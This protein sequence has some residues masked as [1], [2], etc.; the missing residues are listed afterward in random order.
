[1][2]VTAGTC[3]VDA[4]SAV[5]NCV[6]GTLAPGQSRTVVFQALVPGVTAPGTSL[7]NTATLTSP[8]VDTV[9]ANRVA[10]AT[11]TVVTSADLTITKTPVSAPAVAGSSQTYL[12]AVHNTGPSVSRGV[13]VTDAL[14]AGLTF[15]SAQTSVGTCTQS[16]GTV[17]CALGDL[18]AGAAPTIQITAKLD[19]GLGGTTLTNTATIASAP[20]TGAPTP[21]PDLSNNTSSASQSVQAVSD[22]TLVKTRTSGAVVA[23]GTVSYLLTGTNVG[24]SNAKNFTVTDP[25]P[26]VPTG[27]TLVAAMASGDGSCATVQVLQPDR[28][29]IIPTVVCKWPL[30]TVGGIR[31]VA[32]TLAIPSA[33]AASDPVDHATWLTNTATATSDSFDNH[34][35]GATD[36]VSDPVTTSADLSATKSV[37]SGSPVAGG[38]VK[39]QI[40]VHNSGPSQAALVTVDDQAPPGVTFTAASKA[41]GTCTQTPTAVHCDLGTLAAGADAVVTVTG[42]LAAD[43]A[44]PTVTNT[45]VVASA[46]PDPDLT[47]NSGV[48]TSDI[49]TSANLSLTKTVAPATL[50]AGSPATWKIT[51]SNAGP[52][53]SSGAVVTDILPVGV[54]AGSATIDGGAA[55]T[56]TPGTGSAI[57]TTVV[58]CPLVPIA[59]NGSA[60]ITIVGTVAASYLATA[61]TNTASVTASTP[62]PDTTNN[63]QSVTSP[64]TTSANLA[65]AKSGPATLDAGG[66]ISWSLVVTNSGPSDAQGATIV[67]TLPAG[68]SAVTGTGPGGACSTA[69]STLTCPVGS[70]SAGGTITVTVHGT[71]DPAATGSLVNTATV[72][73]TTSDP[74]PANNTGS[75]TT[76][77]TAAADLSIQK[78]AGTA[79]AGGPVSWSITVRNGGPSNATD[80]TVAD[81][82]PGSVSAL[83]ATFGTVATPCTLTGNDISCA[84][85]TLAP[86]AVVTITVTGTLAAS[87]TGLTLANTATVSSPTTDPNPANNSSTVSTPVSTSADLKIGKALTSG[88]PIAGDPATYEIDV[89]N[90]GPS[91]AAGATVDDPLPVEFEDP[92]V[93][94]AGSSGDC[95]ITSGAVHC[96]LG[97]VAF[98]APAPRITVTGTISQALGSTLSNTATVTGPTPDP[99]LANNSSTAV[100]SVGESANLSVTKSG[101]ATITAGGIATWTIDVHN[102]GPSDAREVTVSDALPPG[103]SEG[104]LVPAG[105]PACASV[106]SCQVGTI[107]DGATLRLTATGRL[108]AGVA[109]GSLVTNNVSVSS[110]SPDPDN[111][112]NSAQFASTVLTAAHLTVTKTAVPSVLVPGRDAAYTITVN[113]SGPSDALATLA[114]DPLP[115]GVIVR[116][117]V[118]SS[119]GS[120]DAIG[121]TVTCALGV[122]V[123]GGTATIT[124][125]ISVDPAFTGTTITNTATVVSPT[126]DTVPDA[127]RSGGTINDVTPLSHLTLTKSGPTTAVA[128]D[129]IAWTI[130]LANAG[131]SVARGVVVT[132]QL[133]A[134]L[135]PGTSVSSSHG[136]CAIDA[137]ALI[138]C[139][140]G[141]L[142]PG[143]S[144]RIQINVSGAIDPG[145]T[146]S[147]L[148]NHATVVSS[149]PE[150]DPTQPDTRHATWTTTVTQSADLA[151]TKVPTTTG[152]AVPGDPVS[153]TITVINGGSSTAADVHLTD[154]VP[155]GLASLTFTGA[156]G[157]ALTCPAGVCALGNL[158]A[159]A[160]ARRRHHSF[161]GVGRR[162]YRRTRDQHGQRRI[163]QEPRIQT[164]ATTPSAP[165]SWFRVRRTWSITK[166][167]D[168]ATVFAGDPLTW[169]ITLNNHG[170]SVAHAAVITDTLPAGISNVSLDLPSRVTCTPAPA[171]GVVITCPVDGNLA[172]GDAGQVVIKVTATVDPDFTGSSLANTV[173][174][175]STTPEPDPAPGDR[176]STSDTPVTAS[177]N[178]SVTK[179]GPASVVAGN[180]ISWTVIARNSGPSVAKSVL[181]TD[182]TPDGVTGFGGNWPGGTCGADGCS[183]GDLAPGAAVTITFTGT[184]SPAFTGPSVVNTVTIGSATPDPDS[185][186]N[187]ATAITPEGSSADLSL[188]KT[189]SPNP[190]VPGAPLVYTLRIHNKGPSS[191]VQVGIVDQLPTEL[192]GVTATATAGAVCTVAGLSVSCTAPTL[193]AG[194]DIIVTIRATLAANATAGEVSNTASVFSPTPDPDLSNNTGSVS[195]GT[196]QADLV[197]SKTASAVSVRPGGTL[198]WTIT[199]HNTGPGPAR[200]VLVG[201]LLPA[202]IAVR[203]VAPSQGSCTLADGVETCLLGTLPAGATATVRITATVSATATGSLTNQATAVSPDE[204]DPTNNTAQV[205]TP[206]TAA[207]DL[208]IVKKLTTTTVTAGGPVGWKLTVTNRGPVAVAEATVTDPIPAGVGSI[209]APKGCVVTGQVV[210][211]PVGPLAV[212]HSATVLI[213]GVVDPTFRGKLANTARV[214]SPLLDPDPANNS[215]TAT[216]SVGVVSGLTVTKTADLT[217]A[218]VDTIVTY[219]IKVAA[220]GPSSASGVV[221]AEFLPAGGSVDTSAASQG[222]YDD[223]TG[224]WT[225]GELG[226]ATPATLTLTVLFAQAGNAVNE[227]QAIAT[228]QKAVTATAAVTITAA[229]VPPVNGELPN[230][231]FPAWW[232]AAWALLLLL[233]GALVLGWGRRLRE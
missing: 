81:S 4:T 215:S 195:A 233:A 86:A 126:P 136:A 99:N 154:P 11:S 207:A 225:V 48:S 104:T 133:P 3:T 198:T 101:P 37:L 144:A 203:T 118:T 20:A 122:L 100:G 36:T 173:T 55:C 96:D 45:A 214:T 77:L 107:A 192:S 158:A 94:L 62:D 34:S 213:T 166:V 75:S 43:F 6:F 127:P 149:T 18:V 168:K 145:F 208:S 170:P 146:G 196:A 226:V 138:T 135:S 39:W 218:Q 134:G 25:I 83:T 61:L 73:A 188:V 56:L 27:T 95:V 224:I 180:S 17:T 63:S 90:L 137:G 115:D 59:A 87:Y 219:T 92:V 110:P 105:Q 184:V 7:V 204:S 119:Q 24:P 80:V 112:D 150:P 58:T 221:V 123:A 65:L 212:G 33:A 68:V 116:P 129:S 223:A 175:A 49:F 197:V 189:V 50:T 76:T 176:T 148:V 143:D 178:L 10:T 185:T 222:T 172:V 32:L 14:P 41:A 151:V 125:P 199:V 46:T 52:S 201:D 120:C 159:R 128:G 177:A 57:G 169:T 160:G 114:T 153:W 60:S 102:G 216:V 164:R 211:C 13:V 156:D 108:G 167:A 72:S 64:V 106:V 89:T 147:E 161:R 15:T 162:L 40:L 97:V 132:D 42:N 26:L 190:E 98:G 28:V 121:R 51:V 232:L 171:A 230:T 66:G 9:P 157:A 47:N 165:T 191:A 29:T 113:N 38:Q 16:G 227:V 82:V 124:V 117:G 155:D 88:K 140:I 2:T 12:L 19:P 53:V 205:T 74:D 141:D 228:G 174:V 183:L 8:T 23:G 229:P 209:T 5:V 181:V 130:G 44:G 139:T 186:N 109:A 70:V 193:A 21:D 31:T 202:A 54:V 231:G 220:T 67:D 91:D 200:N 93:T 111:R 194:A 103:I 71:V 35:P 85:G 69:G 78:T 79:V 152:P 131:P 22:L 142:S 1:M 182:P 206:V 187:S 84:I 30:V 217:S 163:D 210:H 179:S